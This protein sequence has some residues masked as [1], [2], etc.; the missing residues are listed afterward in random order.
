MGIPAHLLSTARSTMAFLQDR[1]P[2]VVV[3]HK[4]LPDISGLNLCRLIKTEGSTVSA[5]V[6]ALLDEIG[7]QFDA[8]E[9]GAA[10]C[11][12]KPFN[13]RKLALQI[14]NILLSIGDTERAAHESE[15]VPSYLDLIFVA[16]PF[17]R[18]GIMRQT[19]LRIQ[20]GVI[21]LKIFAIRT[22]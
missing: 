12:M 2:A 22:A 1:C 8:L 3:L 15:F 10:D 20:S 4:A 7:D 5:F 14:R 21:Y 6:L 19:S 18:V 17:E 9:L 13:V 11:V 16:R